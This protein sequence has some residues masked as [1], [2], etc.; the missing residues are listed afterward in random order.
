M[1]ANIVDGRDQWFH[2]TL[3]AG[4]HIFGKAPMQQQRV[5]I[6][7]VG[8]RNPANRT[9]LATEEAFTDAPDAPA[10]EWLATERLSEP[11]AIDLTRY[12]GLLITPGSPYR[13]MDGALAAI[14]HAREHQVPLLGTCGGFQ[15][16]I[17]E[18]AR[19]VLG[20]ADADHEETS[21]G[22]PDLA[23]TA[24]TCSLAGQT[25]PVR[26]VAGT[27]A[28]TIYGVD[29]VLEPFFCSYGLNSAYR[30]LLE[31]RG[32]VI[33][34]V[35]RFGEVRIIELPAHPFFVGTLFVPQ[36]RHRPTEPH[37]LISAFIAA[38]AVSRS[39]RRHHN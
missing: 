12:A 35:D 37:P 4:N 28:A 30:P 36:A 18:F 31:A 9:H 2:G 17:L 23:V 13:S 14:R 24:L 16:L 19:H 34:G 5:I 3:H 15:H 38:A 33:S 39:P 1:H 25:H 8:D 6:A 26:I 27:R 21:P 22:A 29:E 11:G 10:I 32:L 7:L 20:R